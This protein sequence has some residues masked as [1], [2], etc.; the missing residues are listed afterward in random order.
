MGRSRILVVED[1]LEIR[2]ALQE[3]LHLEGFDVR[4]DGDGCEALEVAAKTQPKVILLDL[5]MP[6][7]NGWEFL[8]AKKKNEILAPIPVIVLSAAADIKMK[9]ISAVRVLKKPVDLEEL[10]TALWTFCGH[11]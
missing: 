1:D 3:S 7:M 2:E 4:L 9:S 11:P 5:M 8:E 10:L 6:V